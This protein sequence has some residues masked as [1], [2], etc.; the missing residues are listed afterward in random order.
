MLDTAYVIL[1]HNTTSKQQG[2]QAEENPKRIPESKI[3]LIKLK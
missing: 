1:L 3:H 2:K